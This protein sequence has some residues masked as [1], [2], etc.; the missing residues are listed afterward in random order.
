MVP[1]DGNQEPISRIHISVNIH[2]KSILKLEDDF[3]KSD[4]M[5]M[6]IHL[7]AQAH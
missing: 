7:K 3:N 2:D 6:P 5:K 1:T 4:D